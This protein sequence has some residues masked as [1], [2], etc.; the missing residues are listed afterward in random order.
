ML[1][2]GLIKCPSHGTFSVQD[3]WHSIPVK[4]VD[5]PPHAWVHGGGLHS[6][7]TWSGQERQGKD[8]MRN[9][10]HAVMSFCGKHCIP[11]RLRSRLA[12]PSDDNLFSS[13]EI[14]TLQ[15]IF[16]HWLGE[17]GVSGTD[18]NIPADQPYC[19]HA[20]SSLSTALQ[21]CDF[22]FSCSHTRSSHRIQARHSIIRLLRP[23]LQDC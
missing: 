22:S 19:L 1:S 18:W 11:S 13:E 5:A 10:R 4:Q 12:S 6:R 7:P 9:L 21:D 17:H 23:L 2:S 15:S 20:L 3:A 16:S 14:P 8:I